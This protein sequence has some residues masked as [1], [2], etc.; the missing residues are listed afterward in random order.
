M[1]LLSLIAALLLEQWRPLSERRFLFAPVAR[2]AAF[3]ERQFNAGEPQHGVLA[4]M[5]AALPLTLAAWLAYALLAQ[6]SP[7]AALA[8]NIAALYVTMG[9]RQFSH[10]FTDIH[11][12][13]KENDLARARELLGAW[14]GHDCGALPSEDIVRLAIEEALAASHRHVFAVIF[15]FIVLPGPSGAVLYRVTEYLKRRWGEA[16]TPELAAFGGFSA[17]ALGLLDWLPARLSAITFAIVGD[18]EDAIF[19]WRTQAQ[20]W[21]E[22][23]MGIVL[24]AAGGAMGVTLGNPYICEDVAVE[25]PELGVGDE[26]EVG[27]LDSTV[28]LV[29]RS[30]VLWLAMLFV[31]SV[32]GALG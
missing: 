21:P 8:F 25:R 18:F 26:P 9:F 13:L 22:P 24:A 30:L 7:L 11:L 12:A 1:G 15:W 10:Y 28:G 4:W 27:F 2:Y 19:C 14:R 31:I 16:G 23:A 3:L 29:W 6:V 5:V 32:A 20:G 17:R